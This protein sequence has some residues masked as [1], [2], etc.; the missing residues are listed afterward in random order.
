MSFLLDMN[1]KYILAEG[2]RE[3]HRLRV[4]ENGVLRKMFKPRRSEVI[5]RW[6]KLD[7]KGLHDL[8]FSPCI[9]VIKSRI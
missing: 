2:L 3:E 4:F 8:Y 7:N 1:F 9:R 6:T 5:G